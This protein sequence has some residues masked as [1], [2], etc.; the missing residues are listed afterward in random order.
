MRLSLFLV[1]VVA[2]HLFSQNDSLKISTKKKGTLYFS[3]GYTRVW[4][5]KSDIRFVD[6]ASTYHPETGYNHNYDFTVYDAEAHDRPDFDKIPDIVNFTV[7]QY[8][9]RLGYYFN[10]KSDLAV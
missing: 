4:F 1:F 5:S 2:S 7:P 6:R 8:A 10:N 3:A 9:Y